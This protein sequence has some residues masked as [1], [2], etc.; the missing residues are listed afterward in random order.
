MMKRVRG[1]TLSVVACTLASCSG[2]GKVHPPHADRPLLVSTHKG[3]RQMTPGVTESMTANLRELV[4]KPC[5]DYFASARPEGSTVTLALA[6]GTKASA[7]E[8]AAQLRADRLVGADARDEKTIVARFA[9]AAA[10]EGATLD[11]LWLGTGAFD[12][13]GFKENEVLT[14]RR[15]NPGPGFT[16]IEVYN[17]ATE[18]EEWRRFLADQV[19]LVPS[20]TT[21]QETYLREDP[22]VRIVPF[23]RPPTAALFFRTDRPQVGDPAVRRALSL[24]LDRRAIASVV[25]GDP[26][27]ALSVREDL[28]EARQILE[29]LGYG[30]DRPLALKIWLNSE[31]TDFHRAALVIEQQLAILNVSVDFEVRTATEI[32]KHLDDPFDAIVFFGGWEQNY[33]MMLPFLAKYSSPEVDAAFAAGDHEKARSI[34]EHDMPLTPLYRIEQAVAA[35]RDICNIHPTTITDPL[36]LAD[37]RPCAA[38]EAE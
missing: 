6:P 24:A 5:A 19:D 14:L 30:P 4:Y 16:S 29:G 13:A 35:D 20:I 31:S 22:T 26:A 25:N 38:G 18:E 1:I 10:A 21:Q 8:L 15:I 37:V 11:T 12:V 23:S 32:Q 7:A 33:L 34:L 27:T 2:G 17:V 9:D 28:P 3:L 36:W